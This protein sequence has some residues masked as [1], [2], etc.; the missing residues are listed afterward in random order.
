MCLGAQ[1]KDEKYD[2]RERRRR[3][4]S[5]L[6]AED[7]RFPRIER[8]DCQKREDLVNEMTV[9]SPSFLQQRCV[10]QPTSKYNEYFEIVSGLSDALFFRNYRNTLKMAGHSAPEFLNH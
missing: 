9:S 6:E 2:Q 10:Y 7:I 5:I 1:I 8:L 3:H 4:K